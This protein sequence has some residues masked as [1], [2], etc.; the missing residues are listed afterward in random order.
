[1]SGVF[2]R[3]VVGVD[4]SPG[5][6]MA[7]RWTAKL[8]KASA[9]EVI[10]VCAYSWNP[11]VGTE[12]NEEVIEGLRAELETDWVEPLATEDV[13]YRTVLEVGDP[14]VML[15]ASG[16]VYKADLIVVG[17]R[18][19]G[20]LAELLLGSVAQYVTHRSRVPVTVVPS[21]PPLDQPPAGSAQG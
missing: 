2:D 4:G 13:P 21:P 8:A 14:R 15:L 11:M 18:G 1:M 10:V 5:S 7:L 17:S 3:I 9:A 20:P 12:T 6:E 16:E 19:R